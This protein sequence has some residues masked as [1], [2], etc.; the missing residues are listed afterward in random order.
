MKPEVVGVG[1]ATLDHVC[2]LEDSPAP[3][4]KVRVREYF[5][6]P[7]GQVPTALVALQRWGVGTAFLG[8][9][10]DDEGGRLQQSSL[11]SERVE[12][13]G[14][15]C[16]GV[17]SQ[18]SFISI[19]AASG[20]R[21]IQWFRDA[22]LAIGVQGVDLSAVAEAKAVLLDGE[23]VELAL[24]AA[25]AARD[26]GARVMLDVDEPGPGT[27]ELL[28]LTDTAIVSGDFAQRLTGENDLG[29]A[30]RELCRRGPAVAVATVGARGAV[31]W[32]DGALS[33]RV[34]YPVDVVDTTS[35]GDVFHAGYLYGE[36]HGWAADETLAFA[37][38]AAG[39]TCRTLGGRSAIPSIAAV[40]ALVADSTS[41]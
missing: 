5:R 29:A 37:T 24:E 7:G 40:L 22:D 17:A 4:G 23:E 33:R 28:G 38:A 26:A 20:E 14:R 18:R 21:T 34:G 35:A 15:V 36:V 30:L 6:Q 39:L 16:R 13:L 11:R 2:V 10:G 27:A 12:I 25:R 3:G 19:D 8:A 31:V 9:I 1:Y 32:R 41:D